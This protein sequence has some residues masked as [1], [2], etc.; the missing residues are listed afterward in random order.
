[1]R[2]LTTHI[3]LIC[4]AIG[5]I[6]GFAIGCA[7]SSQQFDASLFDKSLYTP[8]YATGFE[9]RH[10]DELSASIITIKNPWQGADD[11]EQ[12]LLIDPENRFRNLSANIRRITGPARRIVCMSSSYVAMLSALDCEECIVG[13]S[14]IDFIS[15]KYVN[16][17][18]QRIGDVGYDNNINYELLVALNPDLVLLYGVT[19]ASSMESKLQ[20]LGI[21]YI[22]LGEYVESS[23][24]GKAEWLMVIGE[25]VGQRDKAQQCFADIATNYLQIKERSQH[26]TKRPRVMLNTP[27]RDSWFIPSQQS[28][29]VQLINDAGAECYTCSAEGNTSQP[30]DMEQ[31]YTWAAA[32]DYWLNVGPCNSLSD[33]TRQN[34]KFANIQ[35]VTKQRV[36]NNNARQTAKGGSD[37]WE[38]GV[39]RPDLILRDLTTIFHPELQIGQIGQTEQ[40]EQIGQTSQTSQHELYYYKQLK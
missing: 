18:R 36:Y 25:I 10:S 7:P 11:V 38:S 27:Y 14:G 9:I 31:A 26:A 37:F 8:Q 17:N 28:Y 2:Q 13:V 19:G 21:P 15:D 29:M 12:T 23:P 16:D 20:E 5:C 35:A 6:I 40:T 32:A 24:L 3:L 22:Y 34:P 4:L 33:L 30:I 1:M 39:I